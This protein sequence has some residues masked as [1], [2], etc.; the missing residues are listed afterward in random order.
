MQSYCVKCKK[1]TPIINPSV[2]KA[3]NG[4]PMLKGK[5]GNCGMVK[6]KFVSADQIQKLQKG[7][8]ILPLLAG[9]ASSL[10]FK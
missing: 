3:K 9:V 4:R 7:G 1:Q 2:A 10:L 8:F 5:C 6:T